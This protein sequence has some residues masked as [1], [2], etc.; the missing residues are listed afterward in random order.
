M[1]IVFSCLNT[2]T[3]LATKW[4]WSRRFYNKSYACSKYV[5]LEYFFF[6]TRK[7]CYAMHQ[8]FTVQPL[9]KELAKEYECIV[10][11]VFEKIEFP[12]RYSYI[13][14][15]FVSVLCISTVCKK[16]KENI[17]Q[18]VWHVAP[19]QRLHIYCMYLYVLYVV[20][21]CKFFCSICVL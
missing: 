12:A 21:V 9:A 10:N 19:G 3:Y 7:N 15:V 2:F 8:Y 6:W 14:C 1:Y 5:I 20:F 13:F 18:F 11:F 4:N 16:S 17:Y